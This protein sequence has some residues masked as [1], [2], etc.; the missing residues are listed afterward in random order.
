MLPLLISVPGGEKSMTGNEEF[1]LKDPVQTIK[2]N[3][4]A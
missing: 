4:S 3:F 1:I 2:I